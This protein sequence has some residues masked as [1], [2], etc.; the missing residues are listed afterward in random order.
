MYVCVM[1]YIVCYNVHIYILCSE[2]QIIAA[3]FCAFYLCLHISYIVADFI[4]IYLLIVRFTMNA[5]RGSGSS[6]QQDSQSLPP[7]TK[8]VNDSEPIQID[9]DDRRHGLWH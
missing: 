5:T 1:I 9:D 6:S 4:H 8:S 3:C 7:H 2:L